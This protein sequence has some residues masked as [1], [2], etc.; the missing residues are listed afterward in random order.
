MVWKLPKTILQTYHDLHKKFRDDSKHR[1]LI[2]HFPI[3]PELPYD[4]SIAANELRKLRRINRC[5]SRSPRAAARISVLT[6]Q[7]TSVCGGGRR[8]RTAFSCYRREILKDP[9][10]VRW[11]LY[12]ASAF[13]FKQ[14]ATCA[15]YRFSCWITSNFYQCIV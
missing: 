7:Y 9:A 2:T 15:L 11:L 1:D 3:P 4:K 13:F 12:L 6:S 10:Q 8:L 5:S 14:K